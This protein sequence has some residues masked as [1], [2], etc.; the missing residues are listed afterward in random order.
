MKYEV[1]KFL[2][3]SAR[4]G[5]VWDP[6]SQVSNLFMRKW[7][8][9]KVEIFPFVSSR[10]LWQNKSKWYQCFLLN[11]CQRVQVVEDLLRNMTWERMLARLSPGWGGIMVG[12]RAPNTLHAFF[13]LVVYFFCWNVQGQNLGPYD[14]DSGPLRTK[15][16]VAKGS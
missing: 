6:W 9:Q 14:S 7:S 11:S 8:W 12:C 10:Q 4:L 1:K 5:K 3:F 15:R 16:G 13:L 2:C